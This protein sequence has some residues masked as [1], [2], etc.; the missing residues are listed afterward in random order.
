MSTG[1]KVIARVRR[2]FGRISAED[3]KKIQESARL[4]L[5]GVLGDD[6]RIYPRLIIKLAQGMGFTCFFAVFN[7][8][9]Q[10]GKLAVDPALEERDSRYKGGRIILFDRQSSLAYKRLTIATLLAHYVFDY[11]ERGKMTY[12]KVCSRTLESGAA[13][14]RAARFAMELLMPT[15]DFLKKCDELEQV[16]GEAFSLPTTITQLSRY[17]DVP[18]AAVRKRLEQIGRFQGQGGAVIISSSIDK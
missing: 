4:L 7:D 16:Q 5:D 1:Q 15:D 8:L 13:S 6:A 14:R 12:Y 2:D 17:F 11:N 10:A 9:N 18:V 3:D